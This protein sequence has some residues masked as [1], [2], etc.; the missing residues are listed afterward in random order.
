MVSSW[1]HTTAKT[2]DVTSNHGVYNVVVKPR[3]NYTLWF[4]TI[5]LPWEF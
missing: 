4:N 3:F 2:T 1:D 5:E